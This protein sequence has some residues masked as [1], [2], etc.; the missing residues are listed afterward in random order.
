MLAGN[1]ACEA[2][3]GGWDHS[4]Y[5]QQRLH[6][7]QDVLRD[8]SPPVRHT[9][10]SHINMSALSSAY[11]A[12]VTDSRMYCLSLFGHLVLIYRM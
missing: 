3:N 8:F 10:F 2:V 9:A 11:K 5:L 4:L 6:E 12:A 7:L 1:V